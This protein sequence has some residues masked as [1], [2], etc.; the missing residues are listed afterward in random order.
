[1]QAVHRKY[2]IAS[3]PYLKTEIDMSM[4]KLNMA[5]PSTKWILVMNDDDAMRSDMR[6]MLMQAGYK[7]CLAKNS[8]ETIACYKEARRCGYPFGAVIVD[9]HVPQG[10]GGKET[11][12]GLIEY[13]PGV[14]AIVTSGAVADPAMTDFKAYG[15]KDVLTKPFT[16]TTLEKVVHRVLSEERWCP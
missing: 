13:D 12:K 3:P 7:V 9:L 2:P 8:D 16:S 15:F 10:K 11:I 4:E 14:K 5:P 1:L 6:T